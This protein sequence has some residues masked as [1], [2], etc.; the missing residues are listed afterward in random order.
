MEINNNTCG[1][2]QFIGCSA[3]EVAVFAVVFDAPIVTPAPTSIEVRAP[4]GIYGNVNGVLMFLATVQRIEEVIDQ[5]ARKNGIAACER[6]LMRNAF[7]AKL[8]G[9]NSETI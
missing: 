4:G 3:G 8:V 7:F 9:A 6:R 2:D 1:A 5:Q